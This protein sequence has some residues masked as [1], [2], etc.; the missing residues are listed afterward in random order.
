MVR[1][2][3]WSPCLYAWT[4]VS[5]RLDTTLVFGLWTQHCFV[6]AWRG[7]QLELRCGG[8]FDC[9]PFTF[10]T[11]KGWV[12][13]RKWGTVWHDACKFLEIKT[14]AL[15]SCNLFDMIPLF[16]VDKI[17]SG[18]RGQHTFQD[19]QEQFSVV[20]PF[21]PFFPP[22]LLLSKTSTYYYY[23]CTM[24]LSPKAFQ[25]C[26]YLPNK[27]PFLIASRILMIH[28]SSFKWTVF[29]HGPCCLHDHA[30]HVAS[31]CLNKDIILCI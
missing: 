29:I 20:L 17:T 27:H 4:E 8:C 9:V 16:S 21:F 19:F 15:S 3:G 2:G 26:F 14:E 22:G 24:R 18:P 28:R 12:G 30:K 6:C 25:V 23:Y 7:A 5:S 31:Y 10:R 1:G 11:L 13:E